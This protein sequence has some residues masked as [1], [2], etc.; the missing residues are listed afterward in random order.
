MII[1]LLTGRVSGKLY[2][3]VQVKPK[4]MEWVDYILYSITLKSELPIL[5]ITSDTGVSYGFEMFLIK[6]YP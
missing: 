4:V 5:T 3:C 1:K 2:H 6:C